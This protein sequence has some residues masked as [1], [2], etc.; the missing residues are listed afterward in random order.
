MECKRLGFDL[1]TSLG[2]LMQQVATLYVENCTK[3]LQGL[4]DKAVSEEVRTR[5][6]KDKFCQGWVPLQVSRHLRKSSDRTKIDLS[7]RN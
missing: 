7:F 5:R 4:Q 1:A 3:Y 2:N 6:R